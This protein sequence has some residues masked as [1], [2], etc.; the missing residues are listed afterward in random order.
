MVAFDTQ[1]KA[2]A[3]EAVTKAA[4]IK[5]EYNQKEIDFWFN[6]LEA[7]MKFRGVKH[8]W[9]KL[10]VLITLLPANVCSE[11]KHLLRLREETAGNDCYKKV[12]NELIRMFGMQEE[13]KYEVASGLILT[14]TPSQLC[15]RIIDIVCPDHPTLEGCCSA[16]I[17]QGMW[18]AQLPKAVRNALAGK[19]I[20]GGNLNSVL[21]L[22][23]AVFK[24]NG[25][26]ATPQVATLAAGEDDPQLAGV[27]RFT[28]KGGNAGSQNKANKT[29]GSSK[30]Q[31]KKSKDNPPEG[32][33]PKHYQFGK[34]AWYC[35]NTTTCPWHDKITPKST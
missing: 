20:K 23:D 30:K 31:T 5:L 21:E 24:A 16:P 4:T 13:D 33:C 11:V 32:C 28:K 29:G 6:Q 19:S 17:I 2:D 3:P 1:N 12:K 14:T 15:R 8:Q 25:S 26:K 7:M 27:N 9:T 35:T 18:K 22:A 10:Q 34:A